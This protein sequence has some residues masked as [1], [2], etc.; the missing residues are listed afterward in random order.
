MCAQAALA[1][2]QELTEE[3][4]AEHGEVLRRRIRDL[5]IYLGRHN[6]GD[7]VKAAKVRYCVTIVACIL[8]RGLLTSCRRHSPVRHRFAKHQA[9]QYR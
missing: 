7:V 9:A 8:G 3:Q 2:S 6:S 5:G 1:L 4:E